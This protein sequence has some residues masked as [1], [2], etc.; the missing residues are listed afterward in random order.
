MPK[1]AAPNS[2]IDKCAIFSTASPKGAAV[3]YDGKSRKIKVHNGGEAGSA[4]TLCA[5]E[6]ALR[7][8]RATSICTS[9]PS[10]VPRARHVRIS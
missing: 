5:L 9:V 6:K 4:N 3:G 8:S 2:K 1:L 7:S 10:S